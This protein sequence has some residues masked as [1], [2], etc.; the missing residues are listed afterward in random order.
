MNSI[1]QRVTLSELPVEQWRVHSYIYRLVGSLRAWRSGSWLMKSVEPLGA[2]LMTLVFGLAP[3]SSGDNATLGIFFLGAAAVYWVLVTLSDDT[4]SATPIHL[5]VL[6]YWWISVIA[7][8]LSPVKKEA[9][10]GL[11]KL[12][13][14]LLFFALM[15]RILRS[16]KVRSWTITFYLHISVIISAEGIRQW[17][18]KVP[19]LATWSD[20]ESTQGNATRAYSF[21]G[22]P[23]L[24][25]AYLLPAI[26]L[27]IAALFVWRFWL[28][29]ALAFT[30]LVTN[31]ACLIFTDSRGGFIGLAILICTFLVLLYLWWDKYVTGATTT[32]EGWTIPPSSEFFPSLPSWVRTW[33]LPL[34]L[35]TFALVV[36]LGLVVV[37]PFRDRVFSIFANRANSSNNFRINVWAGVLEMIRDR[38]IL[39]IGPGNSAFNRIYPIYQ[40]SPQYHALGAYSVPLEIL[41][42]TGL[43]GFS[44][45]LWLLAVTFNRGWQQ[46]TRLRAREDREGLWLIAAI[47]GMLALLGHGLVDTVWYRP[48]ANTVWWLMVAIIVSF[49][50]FESKSQ[51]SEQEELGS[52]EC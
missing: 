52:V 22:N 4:K 51:K 6:L 43:I 30:I 23:N 24:L 32:D 8:A 41:V 12:T 45:F 38:P 14:F 25:A 2:V 28:P 27:S 46:F 13:L 29:K 15:A 7:T 47:A 1:W 16:P 31:I 44:C 19:P 42:E 5:L 33:F 18:F 37:E 21:L 40:I 39:G 20:P 36:I 34:S 9:A 11:S 50:S 17:F 26:A 48:A 49:C 35:G 10:L 3:F